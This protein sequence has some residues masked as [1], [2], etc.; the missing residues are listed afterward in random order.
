MKLSLQFADAFLKRLDKRAAL[1]CVAVRDRKVLKSVVV[2]YAVQRVNVLML[3]KRSANRALHHN[4][5]LGPT[6]ATP[7]VHHD[8]A[9]LINGASA[10]P[11][12]MGWAAGPNGFMVRSDSDASDLE[13]GADGLPVQPVFFGEPV[14]RCPFCVFSNEHRRGYAGSLGARRSCIPNRD[15]VVLQSALHNR[16]RTVNGFR[17]FSARLAGLVHRYKLLERKFSLH[18]SES[19]YAVKDIGIIQQIA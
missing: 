17:D 15:A 1:V 11:M 5:M 9:L 13:P 8:I 14:Q 3:L 19:S 4:A 12:G 2:A 7:Y 16:R 18:S 6:L 10:L